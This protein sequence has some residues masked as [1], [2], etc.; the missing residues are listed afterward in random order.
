VWLDG[1]VQFSTGAR[2]AHNLAR[3]PRVTVNL[4]DGDACVIIEGHG[5]ATTDEALRRAFIG[6]YSPKY[7]WPMTLEF[8][9]VLYVVRPR[10]AYGWMAHD[11]ARGATLFQATA[12][13]WRFP[14]G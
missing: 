7:D 2:H 5:E 9:D 10:V 11:L 12:T 3:D 6:A 4:E 13:R 14:A 1:T 8:V